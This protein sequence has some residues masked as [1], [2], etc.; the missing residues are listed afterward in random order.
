MGRK[1]SNLKTYR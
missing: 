1:W